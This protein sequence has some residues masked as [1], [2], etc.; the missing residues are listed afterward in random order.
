MSFCY[1]HFPVFARVAEELES[2]LLPGLGS[3]DAERE[4][5]ARNLAWQCGRSFRLPGVC[6]EES[7]Q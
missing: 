2:G 1:L 6:G 5:G 7:G 4:A 3:V